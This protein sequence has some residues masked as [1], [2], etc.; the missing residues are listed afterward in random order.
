MAFEGE[1]DDFKPQT[2]PRR[3]PITTWDSN[4]L[5]TFF[6]QFGSG[7]LLVLQWGLALAVIPMILP[8]MPPTGPVDPIGFYTMILFVPVGAFQLYLGYRLY[9]RIPNT[10]RLSVASAILVIAMS[11]T[12]IITGFMTGTNTDIS[13]PAIQIGI[14]AVL[15]ILA[16]LNDVKE[17]FER[18]RTIQQ[19]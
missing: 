18:G 11:V 12:I 13:L 2:K 1:Y 5:F 6:A 17:H 10:L 8:L 7:F 4:P 3:G 15:A 19:F 9:N 14:N 16:N